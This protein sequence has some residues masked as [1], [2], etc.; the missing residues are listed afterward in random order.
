MVTSMEEA[1]APGRITM[2]AC[3]RLVRDALEAM[4]SLGGI[5]A[6]REVCVEIEA[7]TPT[8]PHTVRASPSLPLSEDGSTLHVITLLVGDAAPFSYTP[9]YG[10]TDGGDLIQY[11]PETWAVRLDRLASATQR[12][13]LEQRCGP[14]G[15]RRMARA[16]IIA[17]LRE[18]GR[19]GL[20]DRY[21]RATDGNPAEEVR[22]GRD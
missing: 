13:S 5:L 11:D 9:R 22:D 14:G 3:L 2:E 16:R 18:T 17:H 4:P 19:D 15:A 8:R 20:A 1:Q 10:A 6:E 12:A 7:A 21:E